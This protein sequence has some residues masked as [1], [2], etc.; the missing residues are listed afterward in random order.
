MMAREANVKTISGT[1][2][3]VRQKAKALEAEGWKMRTAGG[4]EKHAW[5]VLWLPPMPD[6]T[7]E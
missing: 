4:D 2:D 5:M 6:T 3:E 7:E 1:P